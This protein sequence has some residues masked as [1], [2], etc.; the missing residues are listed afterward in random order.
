MKRHTLVLPILG[1]LVAFA[2]DAAAQTSPW[3]NTGSVSVNGLY[4]STPINFTTDAKM[5]VYQEAGEV[6]TG[7]HIEPGPVY[8]V[9]AA[10]RVKGRLGMSYAVSYRKQTEV[11]EVTANVPHPFYYNQSRPVAGDTRLKHQDLAFHV[12]AMWLVPVSD[13]LQV[14]VFGGP[15]VFRVTQDMVSNVEVHESFPFDQ[16]EYA[17]ASVSAEH[18]SRLGF[19]AGADATYFFTRSIGVGGLV[20]FS[21]AT[22]NLPLPDGN[23]TSVKAGGVQT[24]VGLRLRF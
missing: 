23:K 17:G 7:H 4:Q 14:S 1:T 20:R 10:S 11:G 18:A 5:D 12:A 24:G 6:R 8:D 3:G 13:T 16:A 19:N 9:T 22:V 2:G 21:Q 15:S